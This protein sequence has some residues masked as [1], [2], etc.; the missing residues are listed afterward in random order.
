[1]LVSDRAQKNQSETSIYCMNFA[2]TIICSSTNINKNE[3]RS[4]IVPVPSLGKN[5]KVNSL[6]HSIFKRLSSTTSL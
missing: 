6:Q 1:M 5:N 3:S 4:N 2:E